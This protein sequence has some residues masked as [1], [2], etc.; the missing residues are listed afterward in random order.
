[1]QRVWGG[2]KL[3]YILSLTYFL[4]NGFLIDETLSPTQTS[5]W[6]KIMISP[7]LSYFTFDISFCWNKEKKQKTKCKKN[8][9]NSKIP[10]IFWKSD[11]WKMRFRSLQSYADWGWNCCSYY[12][13]QFWKTEV[14]DTAV[15]RRWERWYISQSRFHQINLIR[16]TTSQNLVLV[17][18]YTTCIAL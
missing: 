18:W 9:F 1:M 16:F 14:L 3:Q 7:N 2:C 4:G 13:L 17:Y 12:L 5:F 6:W 11:S 8:G 15:C 10:H